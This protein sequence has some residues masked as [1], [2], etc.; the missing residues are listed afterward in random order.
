MMN[1]RDFLKGLLAAGIA[2]AVAIPAANLFEQVSGTMVVGAEDY[3]VVD[4]GN[5]WYRLWAVLPPQPEGSW[6]IEFTGEGLV[7]GPGESAT[8]DRGKDNMIFSAYIKPPVSGPRDVWGAQL[9]ETS[10]A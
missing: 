10:E 4:M 3:G 2:T 5:G 1:R 7:I 9:E 8:L 6:G